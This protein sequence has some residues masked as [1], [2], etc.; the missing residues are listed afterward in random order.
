MSNVRDYIILEY[1]ELADGATAAGQL[2]P[3]C[4]GGPSKART[5]SV[6]RDGQ[7]LRFYCHRASCDCRGSTTGTARR[8]G[9]TDPVSVRGAVGRQ[10]IRTADAVPTAIAESIQAQYG[11]TS[12]HVSRWGIG[13]DEEENRLVL[14]VRTL[15]GE[16]AGSVLRSLSGAVPKTISHT[17][18]LALAW[19]PNH[20]S[21]VCV[22]VEDQLSAMRAA[23]YMNAVA[24]LG[25]N[26]NEDRAHE[27]KAARFHSVYLALDADAYAHAVRLAAKWR[28]TLGLRLLRLGKDIKNQTESELT[29]LLSGLS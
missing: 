11:L 15:Q 25:V 21:K 26:L 7:A 28:S 8:P 19:Y 10:Y 3:A 1:D 2:C 17:E 27:I 22:I 18:P 24:L 16:D 29:E 4:G 23:D 6:T 12:R 14:P 13:W 5:F 20:K 9:H